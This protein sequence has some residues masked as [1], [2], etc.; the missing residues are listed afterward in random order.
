VTPAHTYTIDEVAHALGTDR[1]TV[2]RWVAAHADDAGQ[3][4]HIVVGGVNVPAFRA[5][6]SWRIAGPALD[7]VLRGEAVVA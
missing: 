1:T 3:W 6:R 2:W 5:G 4:S 7:R